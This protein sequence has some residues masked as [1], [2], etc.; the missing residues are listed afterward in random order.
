MKQIRAFTP[1][2][3][4]LKKND[5]WFSKVLFYI[6]MRLILVFSNLNLKFV[7]EILKPNWISN[8]SNDCYYFSHFWYFG[9]F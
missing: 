3:R 6:P 7:M 1:H 9:C 5:F 8:F 2:A 4:N